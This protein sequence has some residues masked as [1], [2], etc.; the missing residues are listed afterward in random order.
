MRVPPKTISS[1][2]RHRIVD[3]DGPTYQKNFGLSLP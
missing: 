2:I 1:K 3:S